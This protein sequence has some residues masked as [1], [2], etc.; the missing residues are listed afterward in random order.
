LIVV[1]DL[2]PCARIGD[3][4]H[5]L[6]ASFLT[7]NHV[8]ASLD[9]IAAGTRRGLLTDDQIAVFDSTGLGLEAV[10]AAALVYNVQKGAQR[11]PEPTSSLAARYSWQ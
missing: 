5:A 8:R 1:D 2:E 4:R 10:G 3:L 7:K 11:L 9:Q 6:A